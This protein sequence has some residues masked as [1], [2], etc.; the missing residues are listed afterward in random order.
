[1]QKSIP[2]WIKPVLYL[3]DKL[4]FQTPGEK[5]IKIAWVINLAKITFL[6][7][8]FGMMAY[9]DNFT[10][11]AWV[12]V[13][14]QGIYGYCW[15][16]KAFGF[17]DHRWEQRISVGGALMICLLIALPYLTIPYL[18]MSQHVI[19]SNFDLFFAVCLHTVGVVLMTAA[20]CQRH[21]TLKYHKGLITEGL[22]KYTRNPN[23]LGEIMLYGAYVYLADHWLAWAVL[24]Y[25][26]LFLFLPN[27]LRKDASIS[28][29]PG[30][31]DYARQSSLLFPWAIL[32]GKAFS[33]TPAEPAAIHCKDA[34][35]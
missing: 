1:M 10:V 35:T 34:Q 8:I 28:R 17:P 18:F 5:K 3:Q 16:I 19:P 29:H 33:S 21:F 12:Y 30:W 26:T 32:T 2:T 9:F 14:L 11:G 7:I 31:D 6:F 15:L 13:A 23:Y 27:M 24:V 20:D 25:A 4:L 22:Y